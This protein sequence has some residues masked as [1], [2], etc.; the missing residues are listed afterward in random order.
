MNNR[1]SVRGILMLVILFTLLIV[2]AFL[3]AMVGKALV[4]FGVHI[5]ETAGWV[6]F[7]TIAL[8]IVGLGY[9]IRMGVAL[10]V[11]KKIFH[12]FLRRE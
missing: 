10:V 5:S 8:I 1:G 12:W 4:F 7:W 11:A 3:T 9:L 2:S 6:I